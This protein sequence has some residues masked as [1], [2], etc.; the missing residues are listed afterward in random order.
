M[1]TSSIHHTAP[2]LNC[3]APKWR[4]R[5]KRDTRLLERPRGEGG[6]AVG[7]GRRLNLFSEGML[8][9]GGRVNRPTGCRPCPSA[10]PG[11]EFESGITNFPSPHTSWKTSPS[12]TKNTPKQAKTSP[13]WELF[14]RQKMSRLLHKFHIVNNK[15]AFNP[16]Q[17]C[18]NPEKQ[19]KTSPPPELE[20]DQFPSELASSIHKKC[21]LKELY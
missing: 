5:A 3:L 20:A 14:V 17:P 12:L 15:S 19:L 16:H 7:G 9:D 1:K 13:F 6:N 8:V 11:V 2:T 10:S 4:N 18:K 21:N